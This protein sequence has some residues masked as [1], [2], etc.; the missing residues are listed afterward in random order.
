MYHSVRSHFQCFC[1]SWNPAFCNFRKWW[2][3][4]P[5]IRENGTSYSLGRVVFTFEKYQTFGA[6]II[7]W[8]SDGLQAGW[9]GFNSRQGQ[10]IFLYSTASRLALG[11]TQ[12]PN[13][14]VPGALFPG[15]KRQG[16]EADCST[17]SSAEVKNGGTIP[18]VP[19]TS[20][21]CGAN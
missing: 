15:V 12:L 13:Q 10:E 9:P 17:S 11:P 19:D 14:W 16:C 18:P 3:V 1:I 7:S 8:Y 6:R 4:F 5:N 20:L 2:I 21:W